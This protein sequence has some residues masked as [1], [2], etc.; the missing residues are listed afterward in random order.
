MWQEAAFFRAV[1]HYDT[2]GL[3]KMAADTLTPFTIA[4]PMP[5]LDL[6]A[7]HLRGIVAQ[8][9]GTNVTKLRR[10]AE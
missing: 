1:A 7:N 9:E 4:A 6:W 3:H 10:R 8:A 5:P 2:F